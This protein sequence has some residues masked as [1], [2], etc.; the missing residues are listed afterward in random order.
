MQPV[1]YIAF[2]SMT[3]FTSRTALAVVLP[4]QLILNVGHNS[5]F[6]NPGESV[7]SYLTVSTM[8]HRDRSHVEE[9]GE[10]HSTLVEKSVFWSLRSMTCAFCV[11]LQHHSWK[12]VIGL[13][14]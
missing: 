6:S 1:S 11:A 7:M 12:H 13:G 4:Q 10:G 2:Y 3:N 8:F 5:P 9:Q 14:T